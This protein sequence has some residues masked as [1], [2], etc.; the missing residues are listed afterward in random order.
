MRSVAEIR[1]QKQCK[2]RDTRAS[3]FQLV[4]ITLGQLNSFDRGVGETVGKKNVILQLTNLQIGLV[5]KREP[6]L[7]EKYRARV[8]AHKLMCIPKLKLGTSFPPQSES[9]DN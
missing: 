9:N 1:N 6:T 8:N 3:H 2:Q 4:T 7:E 5:I